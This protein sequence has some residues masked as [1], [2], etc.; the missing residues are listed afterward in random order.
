MGRVGGARPGLRPAA[1]LEAVSP[2]PWTAVL[3]LAGPRGPLR[4]MLIAQRNQSQTIAGYVGGQP[5]A[6]VMILPLRRRLA[7]LALAIAPGAAAA[8]LRLVR[9]L[10]LTLAR[11]AETG[12]LV[13]CR[14]HPMNRA[15]QRMAAAAGFR[16]GRM[17]D[18]AI[19]LFRG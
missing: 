5:A 12:V 2:A 18:P 11:I 1:G 7:E 17:K 13:F 4:R 15:G 14:I 3:A 8:M 16:P 6:L 19:W 10:H 9:T